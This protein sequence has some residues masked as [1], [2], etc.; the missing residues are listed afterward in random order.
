MPTTQPAEGLSSYRIAL[1]PFPPDERPAS[2]TRREDS[3]EVSA[4]DTVGFDSPDSRAIWARETG[5]RSRISPMTVRSLIARR[6]RG[7]PTGAYPALVSVRPRE[8]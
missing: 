8:A 6:R 7:V 1:G 2:R 5:P 3:K 4:S